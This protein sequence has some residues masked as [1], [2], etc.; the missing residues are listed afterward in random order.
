M[1]ITD[2]IGRKDGQLSF[3]G[4]WTLA[5]PLRMPGF[6]P[7]RQIFKYWLSVKQSFSNNG[8]MV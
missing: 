2:R 4:L 7:E 6:D 5:C 3:T 1:A 8:L